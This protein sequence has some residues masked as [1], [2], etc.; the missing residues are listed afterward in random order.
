MFDQFN[1][2][3]SHEVTTPGAAPEVCISLFEMTD[4]V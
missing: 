3:S 2:L 4:Q 1:T